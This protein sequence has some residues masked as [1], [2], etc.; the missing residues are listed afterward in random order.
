MRGTAVKRKK[1][2]DEGEWVPHRTRVPCHRSSAT[3][4]EAG[5]QGVCSNP[6]QANRK[7]YAPVVSERGASRY[8][9]DR[10][11][12]VVKSDGES[13]ASRE[14]ESEPRKIVRR[15]RLGSLGPAPISSEEAW[16]RVLGEG[17]LEGETSW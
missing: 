9:Q 16:P 8:S 10:L 13:L 1:R 2:D 7:R 17:F 6:D 3:A 12:R 11:E 4:A 15:P 14:I 5:F